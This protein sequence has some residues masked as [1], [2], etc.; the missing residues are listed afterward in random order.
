ML[1]MINTVSQ[2]DNVWQKVNESVGQSLET[3][4]PSGS[5]WEIKTPSFLK[6]LDKKIS[7]IE[8]QFP[9]GSLRR[10]LIVAQ[11][12]IQSENNGETEKNLFA[13]PIQIHS[14]LKNFQFSS[15][16]LPKGAKSHLAT[17]LFLDPHFL[18]EL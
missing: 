7:N 8:V 1:T 9:S 11:V 5:Q 13:I 18:I 4:L 3:A 10:D 6:T 2:A 16:S 17:D 14:G 15:L 12:W